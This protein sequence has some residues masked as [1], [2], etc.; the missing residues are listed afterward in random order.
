MKLTGW[1]GRGTALYEQVVGGAQCLR[2]VGNG[3]KALGVDRGEAESRTPDM[4]L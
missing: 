2:K 1:N 3:R 4:E